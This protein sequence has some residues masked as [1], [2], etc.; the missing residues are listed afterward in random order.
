MAAHSHRVTHLVAHRG[1]A[2]ECPENTLPALRSAMDLGVRFFLVD[3]QLAADETP[4]VFRD[5]ELARIA[6]VD[7]T[8]FD[9]SAR[10]LE[11][12]DVGETQR[13]GPRHRGTR[14][15][16][17]E[18]IRMLLGD[19][20]ELT[21]FVELQR[22]SLERHGTEI[23]VARVLETLRPVRAQCVLVSQDL[24][25]VHLA[26]ERSGCRVGW[27]VPAYDLH[28]RLKY[29]ALRPDFLLVDASALPAGAGRL[30][31]GP[32][33]WVV[34]GVDAPTDAVA[35]AARGA[36]FVATSSVASLSGE[37]RS[38]ARAE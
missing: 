15:P 35:L 32:W 33:R 26:R 18:E 23:V 17:L 11:H 5:V 20:P 38:R 9:L 3:V 34:L 22:A 37:L 8:V 21:A 4:V 31:R 14:M 6:G 36:D 1:N 25:A 7:G 29:E 27:V 12:V 30:W 10:E 13:L 24:A 28:A 2:R 16:R 19:H